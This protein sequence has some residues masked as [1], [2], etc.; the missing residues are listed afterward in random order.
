VRRAFS[1]LVVIALAAL[2]LTAYYRPLSLYFAV[3]AA[4]LRA[5][6]MQ[7]GYVQLGPHR[8]HYYEGG[9]GPPLVLV[10]GVAMRGADWATLLGALRKH[11]RLYVVDLLGY[12]DS[13][14]PRDSDY[15][16]ATQTAVVRGFVD[17]R[18]LERF[19]LMGVSMGGWIALKLASEN[20]ERV[21]NLILISSAG[22]AFEHQLQETTF[23]AT[24]LE[25][26]RRSFA[27]QSDRVNAL[28]DFIVRDFLRRS[29]EKAWIVTASMRSML[30]RRDLL[31]DR[32]LQ[33]VTMPVLIVAGTADRIVPFTVAQQLQREIP[34]AKLVWL[35]GCGHLAA[36][37]CRSATLSAVDAFLGQRAR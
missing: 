3:R 37:E 14:K 1:W 5:I 33:R 19:D 7:S 31:L 11:H 36:F 16:I 32:K 8:I 21:Q 22:L 27:L 23:S 9:E 15:S 25:E 4:Y 12:G 26:Q 29:R 13:D 2:L 6:G 24:T 30:N 28:P 18:R 20:S 35:K 10:H 34:H 17:A